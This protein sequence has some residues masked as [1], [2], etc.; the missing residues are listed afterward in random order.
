MAHLRTTTLAEVVE[1]CADYDDMPAM[2]GTLDTYDGIAA[3]F[4]E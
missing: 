1:L 4:G 2:C 3:T